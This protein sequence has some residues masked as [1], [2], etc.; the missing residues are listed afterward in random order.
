MR[1]YAHVIPTEG[2]A[3]AGIYGRNAVVQFAVVQ[4]GVG[5]YYGL[6]PMAYG[7]WLA[8][9]KARNCHPG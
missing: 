2:C 1:Y 3:R 7:L 6:W 8:S 9:A 5:S 4:L